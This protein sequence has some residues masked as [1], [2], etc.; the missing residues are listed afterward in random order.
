MEQLGRRAA[1]STV[2]GALEGFQRADSEAASLE[3]GLEEA[4]QFGLK[5]WWSILYKMKGNKKYI[6]FSH[7]TLFRELKITQNYHLQMYFYLLLI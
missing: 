2:N 7:Y 5:C 3:Y 6:S 1:S 4:K